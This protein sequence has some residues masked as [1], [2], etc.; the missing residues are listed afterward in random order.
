MHLPFCQVPP[1][2]QNSIGVLDVEVTV[3]KEI[4]NNR[5]VYELADQFPFWGL[6]PLISV[7]KI[8]IFEDH[9]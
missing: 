8:T 6:W 3:P 4:I 1:F 2:L 7:C 5:I 9:C